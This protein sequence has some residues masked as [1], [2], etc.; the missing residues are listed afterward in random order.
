MET[1]FGTEFD[2]IIRPNGGDALTRSVYGLAGND[3]IEATY[4]SRVEE[5]RAGDGN[6]KITSWTIPMRFING[7]AGDDFIDVILTDDLTCQGGKGSDTINVK[8]DWFFANNFLING[9]R[10]DD[11]INY[12]NIGGGVTVGGSVRGG[13]GNDTIEIDISPYY[14]DEL[15]N[16]KTVFM[17]DLG[18]DTI[19]LVKD[20]RYENPLT[21]FGGEGTDKLVF[22]KSSRDELSG[23]SR[24]GETLLFNF[25][26]MDGYYNN[27]PIFNDSTVVATGFEQIFFGTE[28]FLV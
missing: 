6:D 22:A 1:I 9:N 19:R 12:S 11:I 26:W 5:I 8:I 10:D 3:T 23:F 17:G 4:A 2:D 13:Q 16:D 14:S 24:E 27:Q 25:S 21:L 15:V 7:N 20:P 18:D 28:Q